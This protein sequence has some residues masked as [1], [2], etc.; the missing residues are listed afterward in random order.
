MSSVNIKRLNSADADFQQRLDEL[1]AFEGAQDENIEKT[2]VGILA[3]VKAR[4]DAAVVEYTNRFDRLSVAGM[5]ALELPKA[6]LQ[7]AL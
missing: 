5:A 1:L 2:V 4:G 3:D 6:E 7:A